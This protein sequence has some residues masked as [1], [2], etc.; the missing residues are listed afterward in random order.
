[1]PGK[2]WRA[3]SGMSGPTD[4]PNADPL[5][6]VDVAA[7]LALGPRAGR[8]PHVAPEMA[9]RP[10]VIATR[11]RGQGHEI[12]EVRPFTDG[13]D[14]RHLDAAATARTGI[15]QVRSFHEDRDRTVMLIA[16]FRRPMLWGTQRF[17]SVAAAEALA[18]AGWQ[19][20]TDGGTVGVAVLTDV[21]IFSEKPASRSQGMARA[22]GCLAR[23]HLV[24]LQSVRPSV[25]PPVRDLDA[26]LIRAARLA[27]RGATIVL[28]SALDQPGPGF[29]AALGAIVRHGALLL[30]LM[31]DPFELTPPRGSLPYRT[32]SGL[33]ARGAFASLPALRAALVARLVQI[34]VRVE[35]IATDRSVLEMA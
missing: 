15:L 13:D 34:G 5:C 3:C 30:F 21:G 7:L 20:V 28:A 19:A 35:R 10:G 16:D 4:M 8:L 23:G 29:E 26:D 24:A 12:R 18:V 31:Q 2:S 32:A 14:L 22:A 27:P 1:M 17:R 11:P 6:D 25:R 33:A 9:R